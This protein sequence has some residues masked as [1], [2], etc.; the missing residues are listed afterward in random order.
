LSSE[1]SELNKQYEEQS[2]ELVKEIMKI[3][4]SYMPVLEESHNLIAEIDVLSTLAHV[5]FSAP[6]PYV[7]P[8]V[9]A[10]G[11]G[12]LILKQARHPILEWQPDTTFIPNEAVLRKGE[13]SFQIITGPNMGGKSTFIRS[14]GVIVLLAQIGCYVPCTEATVPVC[15]AILARVG[16]SDSQLRG[17]STFMAEMLETANILNTATENS[18]III[19]ELGRG[20]STYDGFGLAW[21]IS[22][23]IC[24]HIKAFCFFATHFHELTQLQEELSCVKNFHVAAEPDEAGHGLTLL[25]EL[26][27][28]PSDQSF[29]IH[30]AKIAN[31]PEDVIEVAKAKAKEL[32]AFDTKNALKTQ[33]LEEE[34]GEDTSVSEGKILMKE[35]LQDFAN[36]P[37]DTMSDEE[38]ANIINAMKDRVSAAANPYIIGLLTSGEAEGEQF[39]Q[40]QMEVETQD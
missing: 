24:Q 1:Y 26:Q 22:E 12:E 32:E 10:M 40:E 16:A 17:V 31:F 29:G 30:V 14:V 38:I 6:F 33:L 2:R 36:Q 9:S 25:Y 23:W 19:D 4:A 5:T 15:D 35:I 39:Q 37:L 3:A 20:T 28:G 27:P 18:L 8:I 11:E 7:K 13:S 34:A 21:A